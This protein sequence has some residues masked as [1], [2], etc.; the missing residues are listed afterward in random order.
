[1]ESVL[2]NYKVFQ[3][4]WEEAKE[5]AP[6][7]ETRTR[8]AGVEFKMSTFPYLFGVLLGEC[9]LKHT[10]NLSKTLQT[11][12]LTAAEAHHVANLTCQTLERIRDDKSFDL[13]W[14]KALKLQST[15]DVDEPVLPRMRKHPRRYEIGSGEGD[16]HSSPKDFFKAHYYEALDLM[17]NLI[18]QR[19]D[20][21]GYEIY[22]SLQD[23]LVKAAHTADFSSEFDSVVKF[24]G[25][26]FDPS[27]LKLQLELLRTS[28]ISSSIPP[29][30]LDI[31]KYIVSLSPG[32]QSS[33]SEVCKLLRLILVMPATNAVSERSASALRRLK[34][35]LRSTMTQSC[36]NNLM[37]LHIHRERLDALCLKSCLNEFVSSNE[38]RLQRFAKF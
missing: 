3:A 16:F 2:S 33:M 28:F 4:L 23:L 21:P 30:F 29:T 15:L 7:S 22:R 12:T 24:Y 10:D 9:V 34:N 11:S 35:Y 32:V 18:Q 19:F 27:S 26:D 25:S 31:K 14:E 17:V 13:F 8:I 20:Q 6:D 1:M 5:I 38:H 36:L 37:L